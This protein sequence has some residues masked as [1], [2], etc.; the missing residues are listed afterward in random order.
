MRHTILRMIT[1]KMFLVLVSSFLLF[2]VAQVFAA[3]KVKV[4]VFLETPFAST[5]QRSYKGISIELW[6]KVASNLGID[7][8]FIEA[9]KNAEKA[10]RDLKDKKYDVLIGAISLTPEL[11][12]EYQF[13][14]PYYLSRLSAISHDDKYQF[15]EIFKDIMLQKW[16]MYLYIALGILFAFS[17]IHAL[18]ESHRTREGDSLKRNTLEIFYNYIVLFVSTSAFSADT[19]TRFLTR[20]LHIIG[21]LLSVLFFSA[22]IGA[23]STALTVS[24]TNLSYINEKDFNII[25]NKKIIVV[26]NSYADYFIDKIDFTEALVVANTTDKA[27]KSFL[28]D[29]QTILLGQYL[30]MKALIAR[31]TQ[32][33]GYPEVIFTFGSSEYGFILRKD[34]PLYDRVNREILLMRENQEILPICRKYI[35][36]RDSRDCIV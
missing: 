32:L 31:T 22:F 11:S 18:I 23:M 17:F 10:L 15:L 21:L 6:K 8:Q 28:E 5:T 26:K 20:C 4:G 1:N 2:T 25:Y 24:T 30:S 34:S 14:R 35:S 9:E 36:D 33:E 13:T 16:M 29:K 19:T 7:Y 3:P 27:V 12:T